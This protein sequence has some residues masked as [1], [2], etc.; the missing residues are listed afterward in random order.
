MVVH[1]VLHDPQI[2]LTFSAL[3]PFYV[4][5]KQYTSP[6]VLTANDF[7]HYVSAL[8]ESPGVPKLKCDDS[9]VEWQTVSLLEILIPSTYL[10]LSLR[11]SIYGSNCLKLLL[12]LTNCPFS[13]HILPLCKLVSVQSAGAKG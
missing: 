8:S 5:G 10:L 4:D 1:Q 12:H 7:S 3:Q 6:L 9:M 2:S 11:L 13:M